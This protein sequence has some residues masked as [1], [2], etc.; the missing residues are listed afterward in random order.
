MAT[1]EKAPWGR[2][3]DEGNV[4]V[5]EA[6]GERMVG[7]YPDA[8]PEEALAYFTRKFTELEGQVAL[9]EQRVRGGAP[10]KDVAK[11][12][13]HLGESITGAN[14]VGDLASLTERLQ[15]L[16]GTVGE[17]TEKQLEENKAAVADALA[18]REALVAEAEALAAADPAKAQWKQVGAELDAL[19]ARWQ[20]H[21]KN[22]P[23]LPKNESN[24]LW[25]RFRAARTTIETH[26]KAF[27]A[28]LDS[29]HKEVRARKQA[30]IERAE[31]LASQGADAIPEYRRLL[32]EWKAAG[33]AG[34]KL[35]DAFWAKFKEAGDALY[36]AKAEQLALE[37]EEYA[38]NLTEKLALLEEAEKLL[39]VTDRTAA[40]EKLLGI[41]RKWDAIGK[42][43][44]DHFRAVE[45]RLRKVE[46]H[47]RKLDEDHWNRSNPEKQARSEGLASQLESAIAKLEAELAEAKSA[48]DKKKIKEAEEAIAARKVWLGAIGS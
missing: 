27:F 15:K 16:G 5:R 3:D 30:L 38:G 32:D 23:R 13:E 28:E 45:D 10:A 40:K 36:A 31:K 21:Q 35:D 9:L 11:A 25:K 14:A 18:A 24:E 8:T 37:D 19:F 7:Q 42:V 22:G 44:R 47:V 34:K 1:D 29:V 43:P 4:Y 33:R 26:R 2:V 17:L 41:Q 6:D 46:T 12:V 20:D 39:T 48:G